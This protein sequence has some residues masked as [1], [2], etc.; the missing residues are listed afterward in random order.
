M[1]GPLLEVAEKNST[2]LSFVHIVEEKE[3]EQI[4]SPHTAESS[5]SSS[6]EQ[7]DSKSENSD[8]DSESESSEEMEF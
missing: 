6:S 5:T 4:A 1:D 3:N 8:D 7:S 2:I